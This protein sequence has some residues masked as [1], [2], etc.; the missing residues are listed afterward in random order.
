[1]N[2]VHQLGDALYE[3]LPPDVA[4]EH[5]VKARQNTNDIAI[6]FATK[7]IQ[8]LLHSQREE[9]CGRLEGL[10]RTDDT[11]MSHDHVYDEALDDA[12]KAIKNND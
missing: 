5:F 2:I 10:K 1:M 12:I 4:H 9:L 7:L 6:D 3:A 11:Q 8:E